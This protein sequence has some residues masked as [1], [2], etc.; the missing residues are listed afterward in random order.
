MGILD[1]FMKHVGRPQGFIGRLFVKGMNRTHHNRTNW[2]L[3]HVKVGEDFTILD[4][5]CGG[6]RTISK[7]ASMAPKGKVYGVDISED[8]VE[9]A[10]NYNKKLV[11]EGKVDISPSGVSKLPFDDDF[12][13][14]VT[15][16]ETHIYWP[17]LET[18]LGEVLRITK[19]DGILLVIGGEY[20]GSRFDDRNRNWA[21]KIGMSLHT[22]EEFKGIMTNVGFKDVDVFEDYSKGWFCAIGKK[23]IT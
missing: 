7:L 9:V 20:L 13:D 11:N 17:D 21:K 12:F 19:P 16:V 22:L 10:R 6:G 15:A 1:S 8:S 18:D 4:I 23:S 3:L 2:G 14:L 5:G